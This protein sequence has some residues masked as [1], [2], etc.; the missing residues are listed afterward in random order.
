MEAFV[1][2]IDAKAM[3]ALLEGAA[4]ELA[5][6]H[7][8]LTRLDALTGDGDMG[9][10]ANLVSKAIIEFS[11]SSH[12]ADL[13]KLLI[14]CGSSI[15]KKSPSTCG[16]LL[17]SGFLEAGK[18]VLGKME[19]DAGE[20]VVVGRGAIDGIRKRGKSD[21]GEKTLLDCLVPTVS[22]FERAV[23]AG[24]VTREAIEA[25]ID[26][27]RVSAGKTA[28]LAA[29]HGRAAYR[30]D[31]GVGT[32]DAGATAMYFMIEGFGEALISHLGEST[33]I[34]SKHNTTSVGSL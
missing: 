6:R 4:R 10:T 34:G 14:E 12:E 28:S 15:N 29:S 11:A 31:K 20:L 22:A 7:E 26:E 32:Q 9:I 13:G 5:E 24:G 33:P 17:A 1:T 21:V 16:T 25:T 18:A 8:E 30:E 27:A 2:P 23:T 3:L 19:I